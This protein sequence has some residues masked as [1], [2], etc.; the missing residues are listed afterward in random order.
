LSL[1]LS[2]RRPKAWRE[3]RADR[4]A[5]R[6]VA[7]ENI[8]A[9]LIQSLDTLATVERIFAG[10]CGV[11]ARGRP[12]DSKPA[13]ASSFWSGCRL[14]GPCRALQGA[15]FPSPRQRAVQIGQVDLGQT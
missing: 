4:D 2:R 14:P 6:R 9:M 11:E 5:A 3:R 1:I 8:Q 13:P 7:P 10:R 15:R 12:A